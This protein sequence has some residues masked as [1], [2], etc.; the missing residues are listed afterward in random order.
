MRIFETSPYG[1]EMDLDNPE[2]YKHLPQ[3]LSEI[4]SKFFEEVGFYYFYTRHRHKDVDFGDQ[5]ERIEK[6][7]SEFAEN[8]RK[9]YDNLLWYQERVF[10]LQ[11]EIENMC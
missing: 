3:N 7:I 5:I 2:T 4:R 9:N 1:D 11:D 6:M 10:L 8:E